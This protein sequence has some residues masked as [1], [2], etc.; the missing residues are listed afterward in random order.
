ML[1]K[2]P[3]TFKTPDISKMQ[4][5]VIDQKTRIYIPFGN[6]V[7]EAKKRYLIRAEAKTK[8][9]VANRKNTKKAE[10]TEVA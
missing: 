7:E 3:S 6:S 2:K 1:E 10:V 8:S 5:V 9:L 4:E